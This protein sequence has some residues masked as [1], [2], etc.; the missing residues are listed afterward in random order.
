M[1]TNILLDDNL[2]KEAF[3]FAKGVNTKKSLVDLALREFI[4]THRRKDLREL[5]GKIEFSDNYDYKAL[6]AN[7]D[8]R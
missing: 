8:T 2:V 5:R 1:R 3:S 6:R 7:H 4:E